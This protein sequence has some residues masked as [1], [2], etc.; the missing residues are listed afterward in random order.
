[1]KKTAIFSIIFISLG[2]FCF[3]VG[4]QF[5]FKTGDNEQIIDNQ[6]DVSVKIPQ[7]DPEIKKQIKVDL[8]QQK[9]FLFENGQ[10]VRD[11]TVSSGK[12]DTPTPS[13]KFSVAYKQKMLYSKIAKCWLA[14]WVGFTN[15]GKYGFHE[16][17]VCDGK[18]EGEDEIGA[19]ASMGCLRIK[20]GEAERLYNWAEI[21]TKVEIY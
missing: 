21:G 4:S 16:T 20:L 12:I 14:F 8:S 17:P 1:M 13:G 10:F 18:R 19:P 11:F 6:P 15:D 3:F 7:G 2:A 9:A 5:I